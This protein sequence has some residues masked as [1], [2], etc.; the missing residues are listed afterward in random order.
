MFPALE[1]MLESAVMLE[2]LS[3]YYF[4]FF[5]LI[6]MNSPMEM[7]TKSQKTQVQAQYHTCVSTKMRSWH[8][9]AVTVIY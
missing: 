3:D 5:N 9:I 6:L 2:E 8:T 7:L 4:F 1:A